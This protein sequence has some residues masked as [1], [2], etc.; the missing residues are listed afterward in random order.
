MIITYNQLT[1][2]LC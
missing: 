2:D 1:G